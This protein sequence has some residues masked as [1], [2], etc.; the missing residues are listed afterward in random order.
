M[1][2]TTVLAAALSGFLLLGGASGCSQIDAIFGTGSQSTKTVTVQ[3]V[4]SACDAYQ[5]ALADAAS[6]RAAK[7]L[8]PAT[9]AKIE[10]I[11]PPLNHICPPEGQMPA[12]P[13]DALVTVTVGTAQIIAAFKGAQ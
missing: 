12:G 4:I 3:T 8:N 11:R 7:L 5:L 10:A 6:L 13:I 2:K 9:V 1:R